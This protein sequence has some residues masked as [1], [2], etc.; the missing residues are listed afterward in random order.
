MKRLIS[1][2]LAILLIAVLC[3]FV[4]SCN[5]NTKNENLWERATYTEDTQLGNGEKTVKV[6][7]K[8]EDKSVIF[9][10]K[11]DKET[12]GEALGEHKLID[13]EKGAYGLYVKVVNG[14]RADY[15]ENKSYWSFNK[16]GEYLS[17]GV[18]STAFEDGD[19]FE[20]I[21]TKQ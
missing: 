14:I 11:T 16:E 7:V 1:S 9:T 13:G 8:A 5:E 10:I 4:V 21:Y 12:V 15:D 20:L 2:I 19:K 18:D 3:V 17:S 6:E